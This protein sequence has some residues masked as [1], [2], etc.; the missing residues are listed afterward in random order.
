MI[1]VD[2]AEILILMG[3]GWNEEKW[4]N[5]YLFSSN[6]SFSIII[7]AGFSLSSLISLS[8]SEFE[9]FSLF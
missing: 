1:G 5:I 7:L 3:F 8:S 4:L 2:I 9:S 6:E